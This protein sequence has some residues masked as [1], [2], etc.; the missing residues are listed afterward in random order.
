MKWYKVGSVG[1]VLPP[2]SKVSVGGKKLCIVNY[3]G[4]LFA[5]SA[6]C[7]HAGAD[8]SEGWCENGKLICPFHRYAYDLE[9][10]RGNTGQNDFVPT[11]KV[12]IRNN[13]VYVG[14]P[15]FWDSLKGT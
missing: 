4:K 5:L 2:I 3:E 7:P 15:S 1:E 8:L 13:E 14:I 12:E 10:G 9:T 6:R 11:Y